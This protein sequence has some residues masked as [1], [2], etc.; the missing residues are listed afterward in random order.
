VDLYAA[1]TAWESRY[2]VCCL[3]PGRH[4]AKVRCQGQ[5]RQ[6]ASGRFIDLDEFIVE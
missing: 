5:S 3:S 6:D 4:V 2:R 1:Q